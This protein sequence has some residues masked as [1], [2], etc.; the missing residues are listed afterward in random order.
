MLDCMKEGGLNIARPE[1]K[2]ILSI[3]NLNCH[4]DVTL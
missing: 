2:C 3:L 1:I 4:E